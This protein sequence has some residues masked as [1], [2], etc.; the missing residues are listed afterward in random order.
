[1]RSRALFVALALAPLPAAADLLTVWAAGK[2]DYIGGTGDVFTNF[3]SPF[4]G[5]VEAGVEVLGIDVF[6]EALIMGTDQYFFSANVGVD[7]SFGDETRVILGIFTGPVFFVFPEDNSSTGDLNFDLLPADAR[8]RLEAEVGAAKIDEIEARY[9]DYADDEADVGRLA[10]G[11]NIGRLRLDI[12]H[13][14][15]AP[16]Y[17]GIGGQ[18]GYHY[19]LTGEDAAAGAKNNAVDKLAEQYELDRDTREAVREL[20]GGEDVDTNELDGLNFSAGIYL[21]FEI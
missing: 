2:A 17:I 11:W 19:I 18:L 8:A 20:V 6:G 1:M 3:D 16:I 4:G 21:K 5:G 9:N 14:L 10:A 12:E 15:A 7:F 13:K